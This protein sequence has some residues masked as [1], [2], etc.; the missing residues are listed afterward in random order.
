MAVNFRPAGVLCTNY[1][2]PDK[3]NTHGK[4]REF[5]F[6]LDSGRTDV[7]YFCGAGTGI[8]TN[9]WEYTG[10][11]D[12]YHYVGNLVDGISKALVMGT[13]SFPGRSMY[14][15]PVFAGYQINMPTTFDSFNSATWNNPNTTGVNGYLAGCSIAYDDITFF[16][17]PGR[18]IPSRTG[19]FFTN[20]KTDGVA[21]NGG[22]VSSYSAVDGETIFDCNMEQL[23][24]SS[25]DPSLNKRGLYDFV[26]TTAI[27]G[28][29]SPSLV[30]NDEIST[31]NSL[32]TPYAFTP[33]QPTTY[34]N[35]STH[36]SC[37]LN[38]LW[39]YGIGYISRTTNLVTEIF[40]D[41]TAAGLVPAG[42]VVGAL[43]ATVANTANIV[44]A[45]LE[46]PSSGGTYAAP[47]GTGISILEQYFGKFPRADMPN[48]WAA[49]DAAE[50]GNDLILRTQTTQALITAKGL[51]FLAQKPT[52]KAEYDANDGWISNGIAYFKRCFPTGSYGIVPTEAAAGSTVL[53]QQ[54]LRK[55]ALA[56]TGDP[57][58][59]PGQE[60]Y[61]ISILYGIRNCYPT[62]SKTIA[63]D[64]NIK[65]SQGTPS[66]DVETQTL[67]L[68]RTLATYAPS[69][70]FILNPDDLDSILD[71]SITKYRDRCII[72]KPKFGKVF[73]AIVDHAGQKE[74]TARATTQGE[75]NAKLS[76]YKSST[77]T[78]VVNTIQVKRYSNDPNPLG[79]FTIPAGTL[80]T[81][82]HT[83][84]AGSLALLGSGTYS[85][86]TP[87]T[88]SNSNTPRGFSYQQVN[89]IIDLSTINTNHD[90]NE[91]RL[92]FLSKDMAANLSTRNAAISTHYG[93][94]PTNQH[95]IAFTI[96][97]KDIQTRTG[98]EGY[99][100]SNSQGT[101]QVSY[102]GIF[103]AIADRQTNLGSAA[104][105]KKKLVIFYEIGIWEMADLG[106]SYNGS[107]AYVYIESLPTLEKNVEVS[108]QILRC[109]ERAAYNAGFS[110]DEVVIVFLTP[111]ALT[112]TSLPGFG[113]VGSHSLPD[114][115]LNLLEDATQRTTFIRA[116]EIFSNTFLS[117]G[118][119]FNATFAGSST[120]TPPKAFN[121]V[122][123]CMGNITSLAS[124]LGNITGYADSWYHTPTAEDPAQFN[125]YSPEGALAIGNSLVEYLY[126]A[127]VSTVN[128]VPMWVPTFSSHLNY[129]TDPVSGATFAF[130]TISADGAD[131]A[132][133]LAAYYDLV[134]DGNSQATRVLSL[135][136]HKTLQ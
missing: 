37:N 93:I 96:L 18:G 39:V 132:P 43:R 123:I 4:L 122:H 92:G 90:L 126:S 14:A 28:N 49:V 72:I 48:S 70:I 87:E 103:S 30:L 113:T 52:T 133:Y 99:K 13:A 127:T 74:A 44:I 24:G 61:P 59:A 64:I 45:Q 124:T 2:Y 73:D 108:T 55:Y 25:S 27:A 35:R 10:N 65:R 117:K 106:F 78:Y 77:F 53:A 95:G 75:R 40:S 20:W 69:G 79:I 1:V 86:L 41:H 101:Q 111:T 32:L 16:K 88:N 68:P 6:G 31:T 5:L 107:G 57:N 104:G 110:R 23:W 26:I 131:L 129:N 66:F 118:G 8:E 67:G 112:T 76:L 50:I 105:V 34:W 46:I 81:T 128:F 116:S 97:G 3:S 102:H 91:I 21:I 71:N 135:F 119:L 60:G 85:T 83:R 9:T 125:Y 51:T 120:L 84:G 42:V 94:D 54:Y 22:G 89:K 115:I 58:V 36:W 29:R 114:D 130:T 80:G 11:G 47:T 136:K 82:C 134:A 12:S 38:H 15:T 62:F 63:H 98:D 33:N 121:S 7:V 100:V 56:T 19:C 109:I 17:D